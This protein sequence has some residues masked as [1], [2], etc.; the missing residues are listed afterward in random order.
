MNSEIRKNDIIQVK[1]QCFI[2]VA[3]KRVLLKQEH[4]KYVWV[5]NYSNEFDA[6]HLCGLLKNLASYVVGV[7]SIAI[8]E[9]NI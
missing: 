1:P 4:V 8:W 9:G 7:C 2:Y 6:C 3:R 5:H